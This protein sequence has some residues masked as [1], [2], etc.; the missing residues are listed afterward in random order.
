MNFITHFA[1]NWNLK[2]IGS[3]CDYKIKYPYMEIEPEYQSSRDD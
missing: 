2:L 3:V 1:A